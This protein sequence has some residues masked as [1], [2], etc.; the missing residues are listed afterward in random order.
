MK[1]KIKDYLTIKPTLVMICFVAALRDTM[2]HEFNSEKL[3]FFLHFGAASLVWFNYLPILSLV[4]LQISA[5]W[6]EKFLSGVSYSV[7]SFGYAVL[8][9][10]LWP[11]RSQQYFILAAGQVN[12]QFVLLTNYRPIFCPKAYKFVYLDFK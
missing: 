4:A 9:H 6:R 5:L 11:G 3:N 10:L 8:M 7:D 12:I 1:M 2:A